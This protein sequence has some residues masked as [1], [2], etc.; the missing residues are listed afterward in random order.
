[1]KMR[2]EEGYLSNVRD[3]TVKKN[4]RL[5]FYEEKHFVY[6]FL[7]MFCFHP[8]RVLRCALFVLFYERKVLM[9]IRLFVKVVFQLFFTLFFIQFFSFFLGGGSISQIVTSR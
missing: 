9:K 4:L 5:L 2:G 3:V 6:N 7:A 1:M 8:F